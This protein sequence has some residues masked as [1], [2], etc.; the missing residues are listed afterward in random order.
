MRILVVHASA[1]HST[2]E[3][4]ARLATRLRERG[5]DVV[6]VPVPQAPPVAEFDAVV[7]GSAIHDAAWLPE[8]DA[9]VQRAAAELAAR[10]VWLFS[11]GMPAALARPLRRMAARSEARKVAEPYR[12]RIHPRGERLFDGVFRRDQLSGTAARVFR[13]LGGRFGDFRDWPGIDTWA[14]EIAAELGLEPGAHP[15]VPTPHPRS[16][17]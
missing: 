11:V 10:P 13:A 9:F 16:Q 3:I 4:A 12:D 8:A 15:A 1:H 6:C 5:A 14:D 17:S 7:V 2:S